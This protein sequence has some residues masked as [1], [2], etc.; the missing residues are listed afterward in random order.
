MF[1]RAFQ[2]T[3]MSHG[4]FMYI[5]SLPIR[6]YIHVRTLPCTGFKNVKE[7]QTELYNLDL[8][9]KPPN[10]IVEPF[11]PDNINIADCVLQGSTS[12]QVSISAP[13]I[14]W[15]TLLLPHLLEYTHNIYVLQAQL[16]YK[17]SV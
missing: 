8:R 14:H 1:S 7:A 11:F 2:Y 17:L 3:S 12:L 6:I 16:C 4:H 15:L 13:S 9:R 5:Q 10:H